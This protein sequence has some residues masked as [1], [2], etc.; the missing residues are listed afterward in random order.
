MGTTHALSR[1]PRRPPP[2]T[3]CVKEL[4]RPP[5]QSHLPGLP[6][7][8]N[9]QKE[10]IIFRITK[11]SFFVLRARCLSFGDP[12][13]VS[14]PSPARSQY[15]ADWNDAGRRPERPGPGAVL[16]TRTFGSKRMTN[17]AKSIWASRGE[18]D[19]EGKAM[20]REVAEPADDA[21]EACASPALGH[22]CSTCEHQLGRD[23][24]VCNQCSSSRALKVNSFSLSS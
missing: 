21:G 11:L 23:E 8:R 13:F 24:Q 19:I 10:K 20:C 18:R 16:L 22:V 12:G 15:Q 9:Q 1:D 4:R 14:N 6:S 7:P 3:A 2:G 5:R 17:I